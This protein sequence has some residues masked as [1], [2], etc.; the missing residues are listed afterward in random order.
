[1]ATLRA[2]AAELGVSE[3][4]HLPGFR[5]DVG[6]VLAALDVF[7]ISSDREGLANAMLEAMAAGIPVVSTPVSGADEA[8]E[9][10][11]DGTAPGEIVPPEPEAIAASLRRLLAN[12]DARRTMGATGRRRVAERFSAEAMVDAWEAVLAGAPAGQARR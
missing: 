8:L 5:R 4:L 1:M 10:F 6:D 3:R 11:P 7:V 9:P 2:L 12:R